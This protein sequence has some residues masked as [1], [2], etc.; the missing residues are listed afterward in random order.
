L[1]MLRVP[2][3]EAAFHFKLI[4][5]AGDSKM[6]IEPIDVMAFDG[7]GKISA[8]KAYWSPESV[9]QL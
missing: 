4:I 9:T 8:M 7:D 5:T 2:A 1:V 3:H 6:L